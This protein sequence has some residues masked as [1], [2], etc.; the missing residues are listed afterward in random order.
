MRDRPDGDVDELADPDQLS[1]CQ[2]CGAH[3][4]GDCEPVC[5]TGVN[6]QPKYVEGERHLCRGS[7]SIGEVIH[8]LLLERRRQVGPLGLD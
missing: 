1:R 8:R 5:I 3:L 7:F 2:Y 6:E 4:I